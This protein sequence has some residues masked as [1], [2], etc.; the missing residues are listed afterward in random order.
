MKAA[1]LAAALL[2][3]AWACAQEL[4]E[5]APRPG[6][7]QSFFI[8]RAEGPKAVALLYSGG[9]GDIHLRLEAGRTATTAWSRRW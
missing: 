2:L 1:V 6:V 8:A 3:P 7:T 9:H 4:V 5:I